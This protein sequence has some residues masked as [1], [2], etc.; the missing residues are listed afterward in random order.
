MLKEVVIES[1]KSIGIEA[2]EQQIEEPKPEMGDLAFP[3]FN[4]AKE[5][6][7]NPHN[8]ASEI[9]EKME[10]KADELI[11]KIEAVSGYVNF[12]FDW[13][14]IAGKILKEILLKKSAYGRVKRKSIAL[15]EY[16]S[17]NPAH[18]IHIGSGRT[19][20]IGESLSRII[21]SSGYKVK[22]LCYI[23]D[24]GKQ[25][26]KLIYGYKKF[27]EG[28]IPDKK[29]AHWLLDIY[30]KI[31]ELLSEKPQLESE[32]DELLNE[33]ESG[34][35]KT[36]KIFNKIVKW[37][38]KGFEQTYE[39]IG[40]H[41]DE[42]IYESRFIADSKKFIN[43]LIKKKLVFESEGALIID[44]QKYGLPGTV[45]MRSTGTGLY[46]TRDILGTIYRL[47][48]YKPELNVYVVAEDQK[49]HF[50]QLF[51]ILELAGYEDYSKKSIHL[52]FGYVGLPEGKMSSRLGRVVLIDDVLD[53]AKKRTK[54]KYST[55]D[56][57]AESV[58]KSAV[59][60]SI[61]KIDPN[62]Q[63][64]FKWDEVLSL[65]GDT[66]P[67]IQYAHTRC[68]S[69]LKKIRKWKK[70][71]KSKLNGHEIN[72][73]KI[74]IK[75]PDVVSNAARDLRPHYV[76]NYAFELATAFNNFYQ[77]CPVLK[78]EKNQRDFRLTLVAATKQVLSN[79]LNLLGI[80]ALEKM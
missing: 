4:L 73:V 57:I 69:I 26:A 39:R 13:K 45:I 41:F 28:K 12:F 68:A 25:V 35:K 64:I 21:E 33:C 10:K 75:F 37:C 34:D 36:F 78:V 79:A 72:L 65:E 66:G 8:I 60:Y 49:L 16:S 6:R 77:F 59:I 46:L 80:E 50:N 43:Q 70:N 29:P 71:F 56:E 48:K 2:N 9:V 32:V 27:A 44:L 74:L 17:P 47:K 11:I 7:Q 58:G 23:N 20:F 31:N 18:P 67:Y 51:K 22:R 40:V 30:V 38:L 54:E 55:D 1:L 14:K 3:C 76:C 19:T 61:L 62:K 5:R 53:E 15:V 63:V 42:Y 24:L 52:S